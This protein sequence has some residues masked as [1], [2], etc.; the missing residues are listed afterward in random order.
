MRKISALSVLSIVV[1]A[2][3]AAGF[4]YL[5]IIRPSIE[6]QDVTVSTGTPEMEGT[7]EAT[8]EAVEVT[9]QPAPQRIAFTAIREGDGDMEVYTMRPDGGDIVRLTDNN[10]LDLSPAWSPDGARIAW[11]SESS[12]QRDLWIMNADGS[13]PVQLTD[14]AE[15]EI[16]LYWSPDGTQIAYLLL[17][18]TGNLVLYIISANGGEPRKLSKSAPGGVSWS[19]DGTKIAFVMDGED[20]EEV[21]IIDVA[22]GEIER[23]LQGWDSSRPS[24]SADGSRIAFAAS[25]VWVMSTD[26]ENRVPVLLVEAHNVTLVLWSPTGQD[27]AF[28]DW[29]AGPTAGAPQAELFITDMD[30][31]KTPIMTVIEPMGI[32]WSGDGQQLVFTSQGDDG[33]TGIYV[34]NRDGS[35]ITQISEPGVNAI[36]PD[37]S[38]VASP[39]PAPEPSEPPPTIEVTPEASA[40]PPEDKA[41]AITVWYFYGAG[42]EEESILLES[43]QLR[44]TPQTIRTMKLRQSALPRASL[45]TNNI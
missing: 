42:S 39:P 25:G 15:Y 23:P 16:G 22:T 19:P 9:A 12:G 41:V 35:G 14:T 34:V 2:I 45:M 26:A 3:T 33:N 4:T 36:L 6:G 43:S 24:W 38:P 11:M 13:D 40:T 29:N 1:L 28:F 27:I 37:W 7:G 10:R 8:T 30:G 18:D 5:M 31:I 21:A 32:D 44:S 20:E 17:S